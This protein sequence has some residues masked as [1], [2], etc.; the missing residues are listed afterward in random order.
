MRKLSSDDVIRQYLPCVS[1]ASSSPPGSPWR[2]E[3]AEQQRSVGGGLG[4][5]GVMPSTLLIQVRTGWQAQG[6][7]GLQDEETSRDRGALPNM[8]WILLPLLSE[9]RGLGPAAQPGGGQP[10]LCLGARAGEGPGQPQVPP[11]PSPACP[12]TK[13]T[14]ARAS[15]SLF[16]GRRR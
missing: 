11:S 5:R 14:S 3:A 15:W 12:G 10:A 9:G 7:A 8:L 13:G 1:A 6:C 16:L 2:A 4:R